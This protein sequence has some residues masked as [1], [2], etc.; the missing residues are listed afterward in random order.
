MLRLKLDCICGEK[1]D[2]SGTQT[3]MGFHPTERGFRLTKECPVCG[4]VS[5]LQLNR[6]TVINVK[7]DLVTENGTNPA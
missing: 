4:F 2:L 6:E 1:Q 3:D 5:S 7:Y